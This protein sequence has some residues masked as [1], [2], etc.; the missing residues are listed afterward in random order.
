[1]RALY[2]EAQN[3]PFNGA[4][5]L[6]QRKLPSAPWRPRRPWPLQWGRWF[7]PAETEECGQ[8][9]PSEHGL[10][11]WGRWFTP[12]ETALHHLAR[13]PVDRP[14]MGPLV[15][16]SGNHEPVGGP[17]GAEIPF[18]GAAGLHQRKPKAN[19]ASATAPAT[20]LQWGR[21][22]TPAETGAILPLL[23]SG[24]AFNGAAGL[25]QRKLAISPCGRLGVLRTFNGAA[26]LHQRK[27]GRACWGGG[28]PTTFNGAAG[29]HQR[30][31]ALRIHPTQGFLPSMGP[32]V[33]TSGNLIYGPH[34]RPGSLSLQWGRWFTPAETGQASVLIGRFVSTFNGAAGLHQRK[35]GMRRLAYSWFSA[36]FNGAAGLHQ[37]KP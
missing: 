31:P 12:A 22:F 15:Y 36:A 19:H 10:L 25:H 7:T 32:L 23:R 34:T 2:A 24:G 3:M 5:G 27:P 16:T 30:K 14:S 28:L 26:G 29:L 13:E 17:A 6:H 37:R 20:R 35:P 33:Y 1:M 9:F 18:N 21:W 4:A 8:T 11:Q